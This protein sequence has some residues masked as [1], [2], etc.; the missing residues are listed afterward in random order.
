MFDGFKV[1]TCDRQ[2]IVIAKHVQEHFANLTAK[3]EERL[4]VDR[5]N[6]YLNV[7]REYVNRFLSSDEEKNRRR[8]IVKEY[9]RDM[10]SQQK[11]EDGQ[12]PTST[13]NMAIST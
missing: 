2:K 12:Q 7:Q 1:K 3:I 11:Q 6:Y 10:G 8:T 13:A 4:K 9:L 5:A